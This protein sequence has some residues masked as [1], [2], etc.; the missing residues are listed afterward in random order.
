MLTCVNIWIWQIVQ[1]FFHFSNLVCSMTSFSI[2]AS[3]CVSCAFDVLQ[4]RIM[5]RIYQIGINF[6]RFSMIWHWNYIIKH[7]SVAEQLRL[8]HILTHHVVS[9]FYGWCIGLLLTTSKS[10]LY[11]TFRHICSFKCHC[12]TIKTFSQLMRWMMYRWWCE[13]GGDPAWWVIESVFLRS[14]NKGFWACLGD[15]PPEG[16]V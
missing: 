15:L 9:Y 4:F 16:N 10:L 14:H 2:L 5:R 7:L 11:V 13:R 3:R 1:L 8:V 12:K 6:L